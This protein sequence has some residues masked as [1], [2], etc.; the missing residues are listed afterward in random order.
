L[1]SDRNAKADF[2][3]VDGRAVLAGVA[4]LPIRTW[5]YRGDDPGVRHLGPMAQDFAAAFG[6]G[7]DDRVIHAVDGQGVAL[8]AV[9]ALH[10]ELRTMAARLATLEEAAGRACPPPA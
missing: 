5:R 7:A 4:A 10:Q 9:Q 3:P 6:V 1:V 8:A 2:A